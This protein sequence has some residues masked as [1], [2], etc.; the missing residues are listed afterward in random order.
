MAV[1]KSDFS[2]FFFSALR[3]DVRC[4]SRSPN[5][6][7]PQPFIGISGLAHADSQKLIADL[8]DRHLSGTGR[9]VMLGVMANHT[10]QLRDQ[11]SSQ[12]PDWYPVGDAISSAA[13]ADT[14]DR[15]RPFVHL[16]DQLLRHGTDVIL[17]RTDHYIR[18]VQINTLPW[19][20]VDYT[21]PIAALRSRRP[22]ITIVLQAHEGILAHHTPDQIAERI[23]SL[24]IDYLLLDT[25]RSRGI[26]FDP[27][28][29]SPYID[30]MYQ[31]QLPIGVVLAGGLE[32]GNVKELL[33]PLLSV[34]PD[35][36]CDA[37]GRLRRGE[38]GATQLHY[39]AVDHYFTACCRLLT[40][41]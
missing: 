33:E 4:M 7:R 21:A 28:Y 35:L 30:A 25:S 2:L 22:D 27:S 16:D 20:S 36:S 19:M 24:P 8:A 23:R 3:Y 6:L 38:R 29:F 15:L 11:P 17:R 9:F 32:G 31:R 37:A 40:A 13:T 18:G 1:S 39:P 34:Y 14:S 12:G 41:T 26:A 10:T 5:S